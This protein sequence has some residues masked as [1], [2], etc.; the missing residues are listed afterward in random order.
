MYVANSYQNNFIL[1]PFYGGFCT[2]NTEVGQMSGG[3][4]SYFLR[5]WS[6]FGN[7][8]YDGV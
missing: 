5:N 8:V 6:E 2:F 7:N 4:L 1:S 3:I